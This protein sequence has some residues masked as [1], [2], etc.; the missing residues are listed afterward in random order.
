MEFNV[1]SKDSLT[2]GLG[3]T[4]I[5][6]PTLFVSDPEPQPISDLIGATTILF[7]VY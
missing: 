6:P 4:G 3:E 7:M 2:C 5:G 1:L